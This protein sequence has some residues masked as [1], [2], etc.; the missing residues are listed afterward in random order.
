MEDDIELVRRAAR[1]AHLELDPRHEGELARDFARTLEHF[2][3]LSE[4][5]VE[6]VEPMTGPT[7][8]SNVLRADEARASLPRERLLAAA[9]DARDGFYGVPKTVQRPPSGGSSPA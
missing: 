3:A 7:E 9:P 6:G 4:V 5:D 1:L 8:I 2:K